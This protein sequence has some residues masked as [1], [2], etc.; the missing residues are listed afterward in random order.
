M[1]AVRG[2]GVGIEVTESEEKRVYLAFNKPIG[3]VCTTATRVEP[4]DVQPVP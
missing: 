4:D 1:S 2:D 3:I